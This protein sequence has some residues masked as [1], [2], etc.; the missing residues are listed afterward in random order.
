MPNELWY[1]EKRVPEDLIS[2]VK[3]VRNQFKDARWKSGTITQQC[4]YA[5]LHPRESPSDNLPEF[6]SALTTLKAIVGPNTTQF[7]HDF[8]KRGTP[9]AILAAFFHFYQ[10]LMAVQVKSA[11]RDLLEIGSANAH[12]L[13]TRPIEWAEWQV[14]SLINSASYQSGLWLKGCCDVE[15]YDPSAGH[16]FD[17]NAGEEEERVWT[18]WRAPKFASMRPSLGLPYVASQAWE[19][20]DEDSSRKVLKA[21]RQYFV[22]NLEEELKDC[23][24][25][26]HLEL[27]KQIKPEPD[28]L[29]VGVPPVQNLSAPANSIDAKVAKESALLDRIRTM[30]AES[31]ISYKE[32][33]VIFNI[34][35]KTVRNWIEEGKLDQGAKRSRVTVESIR[36]R[37][38][39]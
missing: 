30:P 24:G 37:L 27:A 1:W 8:L 32:T 35:T 31:T 20:E 6:L 19:R 18:S 36:R 26:A 10:E 4:C 15:T 39:G 22:I 14:K 25:S 7:F 38:K 11:F 23:V 28:N 9:S 5:A 13:E 12:R 2:A 16:N 33:A 17:W 29:T 34:S 21:F 3:H